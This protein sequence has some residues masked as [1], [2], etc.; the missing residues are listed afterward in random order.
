M[1]DNKV[2]VKLMLGA[3][4]VVETFLTPRGGS[5]IADPSEKARSRKPSDGGDYSDGRAHDRVHSGE[6]Q[7]ELA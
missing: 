3:R 7:L 1:P 2:G 5:Y 6:V 4:N